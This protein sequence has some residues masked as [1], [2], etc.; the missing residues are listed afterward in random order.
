MAY[1]PLRYPELPSRAAA[2]RARV[3]SEGIWPC[4]MREMVGLETLV[5]RESWAGEKAKIEEGEELI[6]NMLIH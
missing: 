1:P 4:R 5:N 3:E 6:F 2:I